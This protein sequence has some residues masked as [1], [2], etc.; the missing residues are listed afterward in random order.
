MHTYN[1]V[2]RTGL[3]SFGHSLDLFV[4]DR[5]QSSREK[6]KYNLF[7]YEWERNMY[8]F[9]AV[10]T[11]EKVLTAKKEDIYPT[12]CRVTYGY[13][14]NEKGTGKPNYDLTLIFSSQN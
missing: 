13:S 12:M 6:Y 9:S 10:V 7:L 4:C 5:N 11:I 2:K 8:Q 3:V 14:R 1:L